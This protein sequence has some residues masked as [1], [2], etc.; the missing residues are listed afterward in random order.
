M[1]VV[2]IGGGDSAC[3]EALFLTRF[4]KKVTLVHRRDELRASRIMAERTIAHEKI[5]LL[6]DSGVEEV[7]P[8]EDGKAR[9]I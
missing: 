1:D 6:W 7:L 9:A 4:C 8:D 5:E 2:V 3:E